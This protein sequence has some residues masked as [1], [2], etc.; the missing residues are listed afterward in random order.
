[1]HRLPVTTQIR[2]VAG[3]VPRLAGQAG[4]GP[5]AAGQWPRPRASGGR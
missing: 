1:L 4:T 2:R 3:S 5:G